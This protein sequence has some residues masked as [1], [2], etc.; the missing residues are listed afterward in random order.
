MDSQLR[1]LERK[2][3]TGGKMAEITY[4]KEKF[5]GG[6]VSP[7]ILSQDDLRVLPIPIHQN[8]CEGSG[9]RHTYVG[10]VDCLGCWSC[11][12]P[13]IYYHWYEPATAS[14]TCSGHRCQSC[15]ANRKR[16]E[17]AISK[18]RTMRVSLVA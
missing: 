8:L 2:M 5:R 1:R 17:K 7:P 13:W 9:K 18:L 10:Y 16:N 3:S 6:Y 15:R 12:A 4:W 11:I 14:D